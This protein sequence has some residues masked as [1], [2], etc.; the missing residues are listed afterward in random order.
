M[1]HEVRDCCGCIPTAFWRQ[2]VDLKVGRHKLEKGHRMI[3]E[4]SAIGLV[5]IRANQ[6]AVYVEVDLQG[7]VIIAVDTPPKITTHRTLAKV[8]R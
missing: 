5:T 6:H 1:T 2:P 4:G 7:A 3:C 8:F